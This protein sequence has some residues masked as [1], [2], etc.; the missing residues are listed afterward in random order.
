MPTYPNALQ[1]PIFK[2]VSKAASNLKTES[3]V[4]GGYVRDYILDRGKA[5]DID[6]V[7]VGSGIELAKEVSKLLPGKPKVSIFKTYGT[8][9]LKTGGIELEF[10]GARK[11]SYSEESRN[12]AIEDGTLE[13]DQNRRDF[14]INALALS[15]N[16]KNFGELLDPFNGIEAV[17]YTHLTLPTN[18]E[19]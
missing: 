4:I 18:R 6:I 12:P 15:L 3:Y 10:V 1:N 16:D 14:T 13:D 19:V 2:T 5:K 17:S 7:A 9:M 8:A 11:E